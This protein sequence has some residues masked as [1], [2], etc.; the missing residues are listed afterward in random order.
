MRKTT[1]KPKYTFFRITVPDGEDPREW[2]PRM[3]DNYGFDYDLASADENS[4]LAWAI[5]DVL[6]PE[7]VLK[8]YLEADGI[9]FHTFQ[10]GDVDRFFGLD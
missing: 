10:V 3:W 6:D 5:L 1:P 9:L 7:A 2:A 4:I 8:A